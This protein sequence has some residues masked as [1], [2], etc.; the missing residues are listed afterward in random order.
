[1]FTYTFSCPRTSRSFGTRFYLILAAF[2]ST[3]LNWDDR[4][5]AYNKSMRATV[6]RS[7]LSCCSFPIWRRPTTPCPSRGCSMAEVWL[8]SFLWLVR[9]RPTTS[10]REAS[11]HGP[12][13]RCSSF[14]WTRAPPSVRGFCCRWWRAPAIDRFATQFCTS[15]R[16]AGIWR[17]CRRRAADSS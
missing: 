6:V 5:S 3:Y 16:A 1:M 17:A 8:L 12:A 15:F 7:R 11:S 9:R 2:R 14:G 13:F 10:N 4:C